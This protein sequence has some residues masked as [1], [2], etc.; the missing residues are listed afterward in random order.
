MCASLALTLGFMIP[1]QAA[2]DNNAAG[3]QNKSDQNVA[4]AA[5]APAALALPAGAKKNDKDANAA[6]LSGPIVGVTEDALNNNNFKSMIKYFVDQDRNRLRKDDKNIDLTQLNGRIDDINKKWKDKYGAN[7]DLKARD[8]FAS[9]EAVRGEI[10]DP[11]TFVQN[12]PV[13]AIA[14]Q[15]ARAGDSGANAQAAANK[16]VDDDTRTQGNIEKG[17]DVAIVRLP[18]EGNDPALDISLIS[19]VEGWRIDLPNTRTSQ[20]LHDDL[21]KHLTMVGDDP[22]KWPADQTKAKRFIA[23]HVMQAVLGVESPQSK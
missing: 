11:A 8:V 22:S 21:L 17:R 10:E 6:S 3:G 7:F 13:P 14:G 12:W 23:Y 19:E 15:Q 9:C 1:V 4:T 16:Q 18:S 5:N 20:Q 2:Y